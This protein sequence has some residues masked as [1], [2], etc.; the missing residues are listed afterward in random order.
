MIQPIP[1][2]Q[3]VPKYILRFVAPTQNGTKVINYHVTVP[4]SQ[5]MP[6]VGDEIELPKDA[7]KISGLTS[8]VLKVIARRFFMGQLP[9]A[10]SGMVFLFCDAVMEKS[11]MEESN[12]SVEIETENVSADSK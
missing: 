4:S 7:A 2:I 12:G 3:P 9:L 8:P 6:V 10:V 11:N 5:P 1:P